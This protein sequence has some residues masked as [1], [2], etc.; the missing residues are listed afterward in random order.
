MLV[1]GI[2]F[3]GEVVVDFGFGDYYF[4]VYFMFV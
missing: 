4:V 1:V 3:G 2:G